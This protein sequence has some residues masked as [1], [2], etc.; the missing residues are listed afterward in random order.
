MTVP[1]YSFVGCEH[2]S[3]QAPCHHC[4]A[5]GRVKKKDYKL[6]KFTARGIEHLKFK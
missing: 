3:W 4:V 5:M 1:K 6:P 2:I